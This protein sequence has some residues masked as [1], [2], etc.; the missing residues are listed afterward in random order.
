MG[1]HLEREGGVHLKL[2][3]QGQGGGRI[4]HVDKTYFQKV[5]FIYVQNSS[6]SLTLDIT[7]IL[8]LCFLLIDGLSF[9]EG[10]GVRLKL[11]IQ[12]QG[13]G[14]IFDV[15]GQGGGGP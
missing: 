9:G 6:T 8:R 7:V 5:S 14:R 12:G 2:G 10:R 11:G 1:Y 13:G 15:D 3:I 4:L